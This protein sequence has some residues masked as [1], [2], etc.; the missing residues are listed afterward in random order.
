MSETSFIDERF[1]DKEED[2]QLVAVDTIVTSIYN[3]YFYLCR[4]A[5]FESDNYV[6]RDADYI[7][8]ALNDS[9][10]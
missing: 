3:E 6:I 4:D 9:M 7:S 8:W 1:Y 10:K 5:S 2:K